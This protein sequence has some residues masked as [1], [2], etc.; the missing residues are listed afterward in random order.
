MDVS[1]KNVPTEDEM[2]F[3]S[4]AARWQQV[5][6]GDLQNVTL[7]LDT[8]V[9]SMCGPLPSTIDDLSICAAYASLEGE[10]GTP[11]GSGGVLGYAQPLLRRT[12]DNALP[13]AGGY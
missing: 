11:D 4:V 5:I 2:I 12:S 7:D 1:F 13:A 8:L 9:P 3:K 6:V 10:N